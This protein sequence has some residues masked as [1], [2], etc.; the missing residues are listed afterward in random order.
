MADSCLESILAP[1]MWQN[2]YGSQ[3]CAGCLSKCPCGGCGQQG[4]DE[5]QWDAEERRVR[6]TREKE[7]GTGNG[8]ANTAAQPG[9]SREMEVP[10]GDGQKEEEGQ[11][12]EAGEAGERAVGVGDQRETIVPQ[13]GATGGEG[14]ES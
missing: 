10:S 5:D 2:R 1:I 8:N 11:A 14:S 12:G 7:N 3:G 9:R 6:A 13:A 4:F